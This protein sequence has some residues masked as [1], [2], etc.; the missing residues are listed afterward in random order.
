MEPVKFEIIAIDKSKPA[1][2]SAEQN[3]DNLSAKIQEQK[4]FIV[5]LQSELKLMQDAASKGTGVRTVDDIVMVDKLEKKIK[6]LQTTIK[7]LELQKKQVGSTP[8]IAPG[9]T[10]SIDKMINRSNNLSFSVQQV[11]RELP[12]LAM[13]PQMFFLA[14]S[15]NLPILSDQIRIA[16]QEY[17]ALAASGQ[18][19]VPV[20]KQVA[21]SIFSWQT[22][23]VAGIT[24]LVMNGKAIGEWISN[25]GK[26]KQ[27]IDA[28]R[29]MLNDLATARLKGVQ[30]AQQELTHLRLLYKATQDDTLSKKERNKAADELQKKYPTILGNIS[31]EAILAGRAADK[32]KEL[33]SSI[34]EAAKARAYEEKIVENE[35]EILKLDSDQIGANVKLISARTR[36]N[37]AKSAYLKESQSGANQQTLQF[38]DAQQQ[39]AR[40]EVEKLEE[41]VSSATQR[42]KILRQSNE[43]LSKRIKPSALTDDVH[44]APKKIK[45]KDTTN[46]KDKITDAQ[47]KADKH[48]EEMRLSLLNEGYEKRKREAKNQFLDEI[49]RINI[50]ER[51][52]LEA[53]S[54]AKKN[55]V[56]ATPSQINSVTKQA[57]TQRLL[58]K[59]LLEKSMTDIQGEELRTMAEKYQSY[60]DQ[61]LAIEKKFDDDIARMNILREEAQQS[62]DNGT[63]DRLTSSINEAKG[64]K[65][66]S[67]M[68]LSFKTFTESPE[69]VRAFEDLDKTSTGTLEHLVSELEKYKMEAAKNMDPESLREYSLTLQDII[70]NIA[71]RDLFGTLATQRAELAAAESELAEATANLNTVKSGGKVVSSENVDTQTGEKVAIY[72]NE[73]Q[74]LN[75]VNKAK[76]RYVKANNNVN[77]TER[78]VTDQIDELC[79]SLKSVGSAI[80]G[81]AGEIISL[82]GDIGT[83]A[84]SAMNGVS[85]A[86]KTAS[87]SVKAVEKASVI[88]AIIGAAIQI[89]TKIVNMF[90]DDDGV[91]AYEAAKKTYE[92][93]LNILDQ[94]IEKQKELFKYNTENGETAFEK[95]KKLLNESADTARELGRKYLD[96]GA[97]YGF[98]GISSS[99]SH[100]VSQ[101]DNISDKAWNQ[102]KEALGNDFSKYAVGEGRM[103]GLFDL[104]IEKL[105]LLRDNAQLFYAELD[106]DTRNYLNRILETGDK[107]DEIESERQAGLVSLDVESFESTYIDLL[108]QLD[109]K[110]VDF[111]DKFEDHIKNALFSS[112]ISTTY[113]DK[114]TNLYK[115][116]ADATKSDNKLT[117]A[118]AEALKQQQQDLAN[119]LLKE[120]EEMKKTF[121]FKD[122]EAEQSGQRG[123]TSSVTEETASKLDGSIIAQTNR[124]I[125]MDDHLFDIIKLLDRALAPLFAIVENT[126]RAADLLTLIQN[127]T[128]TMRR[129]GIIIKN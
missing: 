35:K 32:Y 93:Y 107:L 87:A 11:A 118:E 18:K 121:G 65:A 91:A 78:K 83:F 20:W 127:D 99:S 95:A 70:D 82:I 19:G 98:L 10:E 66:K 104:P 88:L 122:N 96:A 1:T 25:L 126:K 31:N 52:R 33:A 58:A 5:S 64:D 125:S 92:S 115:A 16:K 110:N 57:G 46:Y 71:S 6:E 69:Y 60:T 15:N 59:D 30:S 102:A 4:A 49:N 120:R 112:L 101:K 38:L 80:G 85:G 41:Q 12:S 94:V 3:I 29:M 103:T 72:L 37:N 54:K 119:E 113:K 75:Q 84:M 28:N 8:V 124:L 47:I 108:T 116:W 123:I 43:G 74:A 100:G 56:Q 14:I 17:D 105:K 36:L 24:L 21:S 13:G 97:S 42:M 90:K 114:I 89:A 128:S 48:I 45:E 9:A 27:E 106:E 86:S 73:E 44:S 51:E 40:S 61:R 109:S 26:S 53:I 23:L 76:D 81:Q 129:D 2:D 63:V 77:K 62:G 111:A 67:Q 68:K 117:V 34:I 22:A 7:E 79:S 55:G 39:A 50:E